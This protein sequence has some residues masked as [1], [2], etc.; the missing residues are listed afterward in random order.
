MTE[1]NEL[2]LVSLFLFM[3]FIECISRAKHLLMGEDQ[4]QKFN[5]W[6]RK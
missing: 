3:D 5:T 4:K 1:Q 2:F 6:K